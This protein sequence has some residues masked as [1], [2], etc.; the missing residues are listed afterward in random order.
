MLYP[1]VNTKTIDA[2]KQLLLYT[3]LTPEEIAIRVEWSF[4]GLSR[5]F[6]ANTGVTMRQWRKAN[7]KLE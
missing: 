6:K 5:R 3:N 2:V 7:H 1:G 4:S